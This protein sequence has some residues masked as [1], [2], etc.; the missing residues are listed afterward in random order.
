MSRFPCYFFMIYIR[1][2]LF[3]HLRNVLASFFFIC[4]LFSC[5]IFTF[6]LQIFPEKLSP[7]FPR[8]FLLKVS[9]IQK[10]ILKKKWILLEI[11]LKYFILISSRFHVSQK[12]VLFIIFFDLNYQYKLFFLGI[13]F[14]N[15]FFKYH[16]AETFEKV[17][18]SAGHGSQTFDLLPYGSINA[19]FKGIAFFYTKYFFLH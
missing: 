14:F 7:I 16:M 19:F 18:P 2:L 13:F 5:N 9:K 17:S 11:H 4:I 15:F 8:I 6:A 3:V 12:N 1:I 10:E